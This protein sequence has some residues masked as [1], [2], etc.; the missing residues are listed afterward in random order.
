MRPLLTLLAL[1]LTSSALA[2][3][4]PRDATNVLASRVGA[5]KAPSEVC[6]V[7]E[8][9]VMG[10]TYPTDP[11]QV[12]KYIEGQRY[13]LDMDAKTSRSLIDLQLTALGFTL[14]E[15][16]EQLDGITGYQAF[17]L[18][19]ETPGYIYLLQLMS[20]PSAGDFD[21]VSTDL[22]LIILGIRR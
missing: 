22:C 20:L 4:T 15:P 11:K 18:T 13:H 19:P 6:R 7:V 5:V 9:S 8:K 2:A 14:H 10:T 1:T 21:P 16:W 12:L 3:V 17:V